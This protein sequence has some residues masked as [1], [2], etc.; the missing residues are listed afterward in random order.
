VDEETLK[1]EF[2]KFGKITS[3]KIMRNEKGLSKGFGFVCYEKHEE[4]QRAYDDAAR[5]VLPNCIK[6]LYVAFHEGKE[7]RSQRLQ[8]FRSRGRSNYQPN[9]YAP[10]GG[11]PYTQ[12]H[13]NN[14]RKNRGNQNQ[15]NQGN[16]TQTQQ[17]QITD[18]DA[19]TKLYEQVIKF[20]PQNADRIT[21][22]ILNSEG[23]TLEKIQNLINNDFELKKI[24]DD[25]QKY[26]QENQGLQ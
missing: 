17:S 9:M 25:A 21:G 23:I 20:A 10:Y 2:E 7:I 19:G 8:Q 26:L 1:K 6:P 16:Q 18:K 14:P 15:G 24:V 3:L 4:A 5:I 13:Q 11:N 12:P 22:L